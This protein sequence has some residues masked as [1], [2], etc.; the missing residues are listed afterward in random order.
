MLLAVREESA[1]QFK[2]MKVEDFY[3]NLII[4][5]R[6]SPDRGIPIKTFKEQKACYKLTYEMASLEEDDKDDGVT[7]IVI[8]AENIEVTF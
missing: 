5:L 2:L 8:E 7:Q 6:D 1:K 3:D 4:Y